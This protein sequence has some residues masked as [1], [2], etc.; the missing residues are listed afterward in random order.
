MVEVQIVGFCKGKVNKGL[1]ILLYAAPRLGD[2]PTSVWKEKKK[3]E[4]GSRA[5]AGHSPQSLPGRKRKAVN[6][7]LILSRS[8]ASNFRSISSTTIPPT[9]AAFEL[10]RPWL[11]HSEQNLSCS[12]SYISKSSFKS[13]NPD[14][15]SSPKLISFSKKYAPRSHSS[16]NHFPS[17]HFFLARCHWTHLAFRN[18]P[19]NFQ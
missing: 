7:F 16:Q 8:I 13:I 12:W 1:S 4:C 11:T 17:I 9:Q 6:S 18:Q 10:S 14:S 2:V 15:S 3:R 19:L 5:S